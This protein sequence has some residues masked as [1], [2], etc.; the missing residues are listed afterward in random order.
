MDR[1]SIIYIIVIAIALFL[2]IGLAVWSDQSTK[3]Y[4]AE[5]TEEV[6][7]IK[8]EVPDRCT[9]IWDKKALKRE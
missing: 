1:S 6:F 8:D 2:S 7:G 3:K 5:L 9:E 4:C